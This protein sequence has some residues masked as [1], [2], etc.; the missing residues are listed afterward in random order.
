MDDI[1]GAERGALFRLLERAELH[2]SLQCR[3]DSGVLCGVRIRLQL[4]VGEWLMRL[5]RIVVR[6]LDARSAVAPCVFMV[7]GVSPRLF[8][9]F[10][11]QSMSQGLLPCS[12][13]ALGYG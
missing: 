13:A 11:S 5:L 9:G 6:L 3:R 12:E 2:G 4:G 7:W 8:A 1:A 10:R